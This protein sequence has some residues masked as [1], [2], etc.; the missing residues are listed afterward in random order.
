VTK[1]TH[2]LLGADYL[3]EDT[4]KSILKDFGLTETESAVYL[5]LARHGALKGT[6]IAK[7]LKKDKAQIYHSLRD[8]QAKGLVESTLEAPVR[9]APVEL[10]NVVDSA[11]RAK[12]DEA[13]QIESAKKQLLEYWKSTNKIQAELPVEKFVVL[14]GRQKVFS[15]IRQMVA[16]TESQLLAIASVPSLLRAEQ[17]RIYDEAAKNPK[18]GKILVRFLTKI[19]QQNVSS[20]KILFREISLSKLNYRMRIPELTA[21]LSPRMVVRDDKEALLFIT[22]PSVAPTEEYDESCL[23]TNCGDLVQAFT[24]VFEGTWLNST[25]A[26]VKIRQLE[27]AKSSPANITVAGTRLA[28]RKYQEA[29]D[30]VQEEIVAIISQARLKALSKNTALLKSWLD[31]GVRVRILT[32]ITSATQEAAKH[33]SKNIE[34]RHIPCDYM[35]T[36]IVDNANLFEFRNSSQENLS[37]ILPDFRNVFYSN[38]HEYIQKIKNTLDRIWLTA[39]ESSTTTLSSISQVQSESMDSF[40]GE[41][42]PRTIKKMYGARITAYAKPGSLSYKEVMGRMI[43]APSNLNKLEV[44]AKT[45]GTNC[46]AIVHLPKQ[47]RLPDFLFHVYHIEKPS[48][49]GREEA[50]LLHPWLETP[51]GFAY[52][53]SALF[54]DNPKSLDFW[55]KVCANSPA[56][57][58]IHLVDEDA[59][60][61]RVHGNT[62]F[63]GWTVPLKLNTSC[64]IPPSC[65]LV[66]G[67]GETKTRAW[68]VTIPSGHKLKTEGSQNEAFVTF[69]HPSSKYSGPGTD[70]AIARD[71]TMEFIKP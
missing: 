31:K 8:L 11:I 53:F 21:N 20:A 60:E 46:Q 57:K 33:L 29:L 66:E 27:N 26:E 64:I 47:F 7:Q 67:Y 6:E 45:Y 14:D 37:R 1:H 50:L 24:N 13:A 48:T 58:N 42:V 4:L 38:D 34:V 59:L 12:I 61:V 70:G 43:Q 65:L 49:F 3:G 35:E 17:F 23:W 16:S 2:L 28:I 40:F 25:D 39:Q 56:E 63:A 22:P 15:R 36:A 32:P 44:I 54:I 19:S 62:L 68:T 55:R 41:L 69:L 18:R 71:V 5:F 52:V 10:E 51:E 9:F 30:S